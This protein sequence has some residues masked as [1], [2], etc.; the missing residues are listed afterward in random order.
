MIRL[1][2]SDFVGADKEEKETDPRYDDDLEMKH[3]FSNVA[4]ADWRLRATSFPKR[5]MASLG[6]FGLALMWIYPNLPLT[7]LLYPFYYIRLSSKALRCK[8]AADN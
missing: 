3:S 1:C 8:V 2:S 4:G 6:L 7:F 5:D